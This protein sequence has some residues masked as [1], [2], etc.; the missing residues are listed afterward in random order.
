LLNLPA[1]VQRKVAA[2]ILSAGHARA[3]L[4]L[5]DGLEIENLANRIVSEGLS[6]RAIEEIVATYS[7]KPKERKRSPAI[8]QSPHL[9]EVSETLANK[10]DTRVAVELG[11]QK[12]KIIIE[13]ADLED[14]ERI[15]KIIR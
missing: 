10:L 2:G 9:K 11:Q 5:V 15:A 13:F 6:V 1:S 3:L 12:G 8:A 4:S 14:L 7:N